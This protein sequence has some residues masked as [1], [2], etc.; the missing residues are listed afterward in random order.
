MRTIDEIKKEIEDLEQKR[1]YEQM[2]DFM[3]WANYNELTRK[4]TELKSELAELE[5]E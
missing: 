4:I 5:K 3:N 2:A 1:F